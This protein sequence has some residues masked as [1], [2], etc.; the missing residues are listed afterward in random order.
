MKN[1]GQVLSPINGPNTNG[2][3]TDR[4]IPCTEEANFDG[5]STGTFRIPQETILGRRIEIPGSDNFL[6]NLKC[7]TPKQIERLII[8]I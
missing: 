6:K 3:K 4:I 5:N 1:P 7:L 2:P 8:P